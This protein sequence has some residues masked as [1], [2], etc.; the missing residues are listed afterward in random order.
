MDLEQSMATVWARRA[1]RA[2]ARAD[3][4][5]AQLSV[6]MDALDKIIHTG[7]RDDVW[8]AEALGAVIQIKGM[9]D[10]HTND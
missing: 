6:A 4:A 3:L 2:V 8:V 9:G 7:Y 5:E 1:R 10:G